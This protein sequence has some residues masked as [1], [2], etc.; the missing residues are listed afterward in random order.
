MGCWYPPLSRP[1]AQPAGRVSLLLLSPPLLSLL[2]VSFHCA[3]PAV[4]A[5]GRRAVV[6]RPGPLGVR[7][8][9]RGG[10]VLVARLD[11]ADQLGVLGPRLVA[12]SGATWR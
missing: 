3:A 5:P 6:G 1:A 12:A 9:E 2:V 4:A 11:R 7:A 8:R 10:P